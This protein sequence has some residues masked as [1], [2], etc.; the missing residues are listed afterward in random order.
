EWSVNI[1][2][3]DIVACGWLVHDEAV[4]RGATGVITGTDDQRPQVRNEA[5]LPADCLLV[6]LGRVQ[7]PIDCIQVPEA[8][9]FQL[10]MRLQYLHDASVLRDI[11]FHAGVTGRR[12]D[13]RH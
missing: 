8:E 7:L 13:A 4:L 11:A 6:K 12:C 9:F 2:P 5:L 1:A 3:P 10:R